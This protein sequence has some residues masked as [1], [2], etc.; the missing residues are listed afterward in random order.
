VTLVLGGDSASFAALE[1]AI[2]Q[3]SRDEKLRRANRQSFCFDCLLARRLSRAVMAHRGRQAPDR[4]KNET[5]KARIRPRL[6]TG[7][8]V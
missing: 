3:I 8:S 2:D 5:N 1:I 6:R 7:S 4:M